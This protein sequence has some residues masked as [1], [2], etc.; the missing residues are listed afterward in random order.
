MRRLLGLGLICAASWLVAGCGGGSGSSSGSGGSSLSSIEKTGTF[1]LFFSGGAAPGVDHAWLT[2]YKIAFNVDAN[3]PWDP[4]DTTWKVVN[5]SAPVTFDMAS[6]AGFIVGNSSGGV[7]VPAGTYNQIRL[8]LSPHDDVTAPMPTVSVSSATSTTT[9]TKT[10]TYRAQLDYDSG[11][12]GASVPIEIPNVQSGL[13]LDRGV[14]IAANQWSVLT[15]HIDVDRSIVRFN[16]GGA[17]DAVTMRPRTY[18]YGYNPQATTV[19]SGALD[20][21]YL[22]GAP[23]ASAPP[24]CVSD[25]TVSLFALSGDNKRMENWGTVKVN[26]TGVNSSSGTPVTVAD[27]TFSLGPVSAVTGDNNPTSY[28][29]IIR[30]K[31][32][33]TM[34]VKDIPI[35]LLSDYI[36]CSWSTAAG[37]GDTADAAMV[38]RPVIDSSPR[39]V[40]LAP[41]L[42]LKTGRVGLG[43]TLPGR[44]PYE[45]HAANTD[46]F[47]G[48]LT[49]AA[50]LTIPGAASGDVLVADYSAIKNSCT[51]YGHTPPSDLAIPNDPATGALFIATNPSEGAGVFTPFALGTFYTDG[52][53]ASTLYATGPTFSVAEPTP[54]ASSTTGQVSVSITGLNGSWANKAQLIVSDV[55]GIVLTQ[56]V[57][58]C[59]TASTCS[60]TGASALTLP[61]GTAANA[62]ATGVYEFAVRYWNSSAPGSAVVSGGTMKWARASTFVNLRSATT[63]AV[64]I[65]VP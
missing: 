1:S 39:T 31:N 46:P 9:T 50:A 51:A 65:T 30:G 17:T 42:A 64:S 4:S 40:T 48:L 55:G 35:G 43:F 56:D 10:L 15:T 18:T 34:V 21:T 12:G 60:F 53:L 57:S 24:N 59:T 5:L 47:T 3:R 25:V 63:G 37:S 32:M 49:A 29:V 8:F 23:G 20:P 11:S 2:V 58:A 19:I 45:V 38:I 14:V 33:K 62:T 6:A 7:V 36:G 28:D 44:L 26:N 41:A 61:A 54:V 27:G 13:K 16:G 22:C 52:T